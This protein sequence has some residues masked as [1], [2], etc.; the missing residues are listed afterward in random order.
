MSFAIDRLEKRL[1]AYP[2]VFWER[3]G[4]SLSVPRLTE[5]G[6]DLRFDDLSSGYRVTFD[7]W[8]ERFDGLADAIACFER[9][10][11]SDCRIR[12]SVYGGRPARWTL[13]VR[14]GP[15]WEAQSTTQALLVP[16]WR[17][18]SDIFLRNLP[19]EAA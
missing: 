4:A 11:S 12:V 18:R 9:G 14:E 7:G 15:K 5:R 16:F 10:L 2:Q 13:E 3:A 8:S 1:Q 19:D 6:F 17:T